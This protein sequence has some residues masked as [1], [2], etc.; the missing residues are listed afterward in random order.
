MQ[1][2]EHTE[3]FLLEA[4]PDASLAHSVATELLR[5]RGSLAEISRSLYNAHEQEAFAEEIDLLS[6]RIAVWAAELTVGGLIDKAKAVLQAVEKSWTGLGFKLV[7][8]T[9]EQLEVFAKH[10][11]RSWR[12]APLKH[13]RELKSAKPLL[14]QVFDVSDLCFFPN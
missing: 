5:N 1:C 4:R 3:T 12:P 14:D 10:D 11:E 7:E 2:L 6:S 8:Y 13:L 9:Q